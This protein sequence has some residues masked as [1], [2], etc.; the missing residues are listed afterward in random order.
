MRATYIAITTVFLA[1]PVLSYG[2]PAADRSCAAIFAGEPDATQ[3]Q[4]ATLP[5][6]GHV[7]LAESKNWANQHL[8]GAAVE[9][10]IETDPVSFTVAV[11]KVEIERVEAGGN[12]M[13]IPNLRRYKRGYVMPW[14]STMRI[15]GPDGKPVVEVRCSRA[16]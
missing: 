15:D 16:K 2:Q 8:D 10:D 7:L 14:N 12:V 3:A 4:P 13:Q 9:F 1:V 5:A 11:N 6:S